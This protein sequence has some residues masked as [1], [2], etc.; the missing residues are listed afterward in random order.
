M[1]I[2]YR[3]AAAFCLFAVCATG[4]LWSQASLSTLRGAVTDPSGSATPGA[5][6]SLKDPITG[7]EVRGAKTDAAGNYELIDLKPGEYKLACTLAGFKPFVA[8]HVLLDAGQVR[9]IDIPLAVGQPTQ[10]ITVSAGAAVIETESGTIG[11]EL[12]KKQIEDAPM[13]DTYPSPSVLLTMMPGIQG[14]TGGLAGLRISGQ[15]SSQQSEGF[16]GVTNDL[17]GGNSNNPS[18]F[19]EVTAITVNAPAESS[20]LAYHNLTTKSGSNEFHG[21]AFYKIYSSGLMA[22]NFFAAQRTPYLEHAWEM[23]LSG[24]IVKNKTFFYATWYSERIPLGSLVTSTVPTA[25]MR[26]GNFAGRTTIKDPLNNYQPFPGNVIPANRVS[27]VSQGLQDLLYP[28]PARNASDAYYSVNNNP[29]VFPH[30]SDLFRGD[31]PMVRVDE[32]IS[33]K[34]QLYARWLMRRTP[35]ILQN[36]LPTELWTR[37]R[38]NQ[39][40]AVVD[41]HIISP[42]LVNTLRLGLSREYITDGNTVEGVTPADGSKILSQV[43]L[44]GSNPGSTTGQGLPSIS[45]SGLT[46]LATPSGGVQSNNYIYTLDDSISKTIGRHVLKFGGVY[47]TFTQFT[48]VIPNYGSFSFDGS[49]TGLS[50]AD[51][52]LGIP[53]QS[54]RLAPLSNR[55]EHAGEAGFFAQDSFKVN[56]NLTVGYGLRWDY[57]VSPTYDDRLMYTFDPASRSVVIPEEALSHVSPLY[58]ANIP[59]TSGNVTPR[60]DRG[61]FRPRLSFAYRLAPKLVVRGGYGAFTERIGYFGLVN[62]GGPFQIAETYQNQGEQPVLFQFPNPYP[63]SLASAIVPSQSVIAFPSQVNN[64]TIHQFNLS[65]E[66]EIAGM[67]LR[68]SYIGTRSRGMNYSLNVNLPEPSLVPFTTSRRPFANLVNVTEYRSDGSAN[69]NALQLEAKRRAGNLTFDAHYTWQKNLYNYADLENPYDVTSHW[70]NET[71]TRRKYFVGSVV[72]RLP[73][74]RGER[75]LGHAPRA[76]EAVIGNWQLYWIT[77]LGSGLF[78]SPSFSG[79]NPSN[80]GVSGG[81]PDLVGNPVPESGRSYTGWWSKSAF[82]LPPA[83]RFGDALPYSLEGQPLNVHHLSIKK[84]FQITERVS[85]TLTGAISNL[86]NHPQFYGVQTNISTAGFGTYTSTF[87]LQTSNESAAQRQITFQ[88]RIE[89]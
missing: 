68:A 84:R 78:Y 57:F 50:Y 36:G 61:N 51:F 20:R 44:M 8:D 52:L 79:T 74:G 41:T 33:S 85:Y 31:W 58:P 15:S 89:F 59:V 26:S 12:G 73:V 65:L 48:G 29:W 42:S 43:G 72:W 67:G 13:I 55:T 49:M 17:G 37:W 6:I 88:G 62:G 54:T 21:V 75:F 83:G 32:Q 71:A 16:D 60:S 77:Y 45:I 19:S 81:L 22:R 10:E 38:D 69:Y 2:S 56:R 40:W 39:Q 82:A 1:S 63:A 3:F 46:S 24:P 47:Q 70:T 23:D 4:P 86:F 11:G 7:A 87:G 64:G 53:R 14:G 27:P 80:T 34:N 66:R 5:Q 35:Y 30:A 76:I 25:T 18:F 9:R 28:L